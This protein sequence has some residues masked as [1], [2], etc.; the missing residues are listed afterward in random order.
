MRR[1][2]LTWC[3]QV[4]D[5][6]IMAVA[7]HCKQLELLSIYGLRG[8]TDQ[9]IALL[10]APGGCRGTLRTL[11]VHGCCNISTRSNEDL[12]ELFPKLTCFI[13]HS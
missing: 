4:D 6:G 8:V 12:L 10:A 9:S 1:L 13:H 3:V 7:T 5:F 2:N 11:D